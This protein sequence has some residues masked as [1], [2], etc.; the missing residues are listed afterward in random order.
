MAIAAHGLEDRATR[1]IVMILAAYVFFTLIDTSVKWLV[2]AGIPAFQLAFM[3]YLG[4]FIIS[5]G[6]ILRQGASWSSFATDHLGLVVLRAVVLTSATLVNFITLKYLSLTVTGTIMFSSP[7]IVCLLSWPLLGERV[8]P[9]RWFAIML[10]FVGVLIVIRPFGA[11]VHP[12]AIL[13]LYNAAAM[14]LY[15]IITRKIAGKVAA[16]TMQVYMGAIG[17]ITLLP[18]ALWVWQAPDNPTDWAL[19]ILLGIWGWA[20]HEIFSRAHSYAPANTLMPYSYCF[21]LYLTLS[22]YLVFGD[23]PDL[24]TIVGASV[25]VVS[26]LIIW[27]RT[28]KRG[29]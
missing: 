1:G 7:I 5:T 11:A 29:S 4:H 17:T 3:R 14:A 6:M 18:F 12:I 15:S 16:E 2:L 22:S 25:I 13:S 23:V 20:G 19:L 24:W 8:G 10:G 21:L 9:W 28:L 27:R 26:G